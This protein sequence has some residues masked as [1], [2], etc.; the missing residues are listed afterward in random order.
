MIVLI[1]YDNVDLLEKTRGVDSVVTRLVT[2]IGFNALAG[3]PRVHVRLYGGWYEGSGRTRQAQKLLADVAAAFPK[4]ISVSNGTSTA[5]FIVAAE[6][7]SSLAVEPS[8]EYMRTYRPR[9]GVGP[10][11]S[12]TQP[13]GGCASP[14]TCTLAVVETLVTTGRC[15]ASGCNVLMSDIITRP[16]QKLVDTLM[17]ADLIHFA[18]TS[19]SW[20]AI[21][22]S[23]DDLWPGIRTAVRFGTPII[24]LQTKS[25]RRPSSTY[26]PNTSTYSYRPF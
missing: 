1:D 25:G 8:F 18:A 11:T 6:L 26:L 4:P 14:T 5:T 10:L 23:D 15:P 13:F 2:N 19:T 12:A 21:A 22:S 3:T 20:V 16:Q 17:T 7:V 24:H 9:G